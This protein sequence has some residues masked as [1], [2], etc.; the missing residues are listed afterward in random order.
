MVMNSTDLQFKEITYQQS[1]LDLVSSGEYVCF[2]SP[3]A[4]NRK[5]VSDYKSSLRCFSGL[6]LHTKKSSGKVT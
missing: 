1:I 3:H 5:F 6:H 2:R 4:I